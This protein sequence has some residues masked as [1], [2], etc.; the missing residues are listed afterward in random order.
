MN[1]EIYKRELDTP[2]EL[3]ARILDTVARVKK[4]SEDRLRRTTRDL[5]TRV[6]KCTEAGGGIFRTF[7][8][9]CNKSVIMGRD[10]SVGTATRYRLDGPGIESQLGGEIF[11]TS[12][13]RPWGPPS[14]LYDGKK[15]KV[16]VSRDRPRW[17]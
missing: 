2:N 1:C 12:P 4:K 5:R 9:N 10:S 15:V 8:A 11:C 7:I 3:L 17:P 16:K 13:A 6:A 14:L